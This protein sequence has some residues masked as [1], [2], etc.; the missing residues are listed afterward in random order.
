MCVCVC[1]WR[2]PD[3]LAWGIVC[4]LSYTETHVGAHNSTQV[5]S[6]LIHQTALKRLSSSSS[7]LG[8]SLL[9]VCHT[10][11]RSSAAPRKVKPAV[12]W[13]LRL[14]V[15]WRCTGSATSSSSGVCSV[16]FFFYVSLEHNYDHICCMFIY[17]NDVQWVCSPWGTYVLLKGILTACK[18]Y[19][20]SHFSTLS[21]I[22]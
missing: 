11:L 1:A 18:V 4:L 12:V 15:S 10:H 14:E 3:F 20:V 17:L 5:T 16:L 2:Y 8:V 22:D 19:L 7:S 13:T 6:I 9:S 21:A